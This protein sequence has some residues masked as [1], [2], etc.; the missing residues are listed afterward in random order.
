MEDAPRT[1]SSRRGVLGRGLLLVAGALGIGAA[2][3]PGSARAARKLGVTQLRLYGQNF[4]LHAPSHRPGRIPANGERHNA[5]GELLDRRGGTV[6]GHFSAAHLTH[7]SPFTAAVSS[8][9]IHTFTLGDGTIHGI[10]SAVRG[11]DGQ[12]LVLGGTGRYAGIQ[13]SYLAQQGTRE[14]G[15]NGTAE[16]RLTLTRRE[17]SHGAI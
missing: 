14:L 1:L 6:I 11:A 16:F 7:D 12:F 10:G 3:R 8:L 5:Y 17:G 9:E 2:G 13:G 4:H 15:G